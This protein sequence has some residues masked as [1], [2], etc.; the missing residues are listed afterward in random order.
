M[1]IKR[2]KQQSAFHES[3]LDGRST[4]VIDG[5]TNFLKPQGVTLKLRIAIDDK[6]WNTVSAD[7]NRQIWRFFQLTAQPRS[8]LS[9][10]FFYRCRFVIACCC[11]SKSCGRRSC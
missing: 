6:H 2:L 1:R 5:S 7:T 11:F 3:W 4:K 8:F 10:Y 9:C